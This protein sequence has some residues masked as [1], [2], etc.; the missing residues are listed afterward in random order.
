MYSSIQRKSTFGASRISCQ[1][2]RPSEFHS[3]SMAAL[4]V[5]IHVQVYV[6]YVSFVQTKN[7]S[8]LRHRGLKTEDFYDVMS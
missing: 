6:T 7:R 8:I 5:S 3:A 2:G 1:S 4:S